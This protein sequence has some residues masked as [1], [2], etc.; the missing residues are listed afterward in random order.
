MV[1]WQ[2]LVCFSTN[3]AC[4]RCRLYISL[5]AIRTGFLLTGWSISKQH[6]L[7]QCRKKNKPQ[8][9]VYTFTLDDYICWPTGERGRSNLASW[10]I[11]QCTV[12]IIDKPTASGFCCYSSVIVQSMNLAVSAVL[13]SLYIAAG[14]CVSHTQS[15]S[16]S[17]GFAFKA[18]DCPSSHT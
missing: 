8:S 15:H 16:C 5:W 14:G 1:G 9:G 12:I 3:C 6:I 2:R 13:T 17:G 11:W 10:S 4:H 18:S 7:G